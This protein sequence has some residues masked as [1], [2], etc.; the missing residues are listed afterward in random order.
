MD[1][2]GYVR[3]K[4]TPMV[5][6]IKTRKPLYDYYS[7]LN[8]DKPKVYNSD[9]REYDFYFIRDVHTA[10]K[11]YSETGR[12]FIW[13]RYNFGFKTHFYTHNAML[14]QMGKPEVKY[15]MLIESREI[16]PK[17]YRIFKKHPGLSKE[18]KRIFSFDDEIL[19]VL[20][21]ASFYPFSAAPWYGRYDPDAIKDDL[22]INKSKDVSFLASNKTMCEMHRIRL[23]AAR[24]CHRN[25]LA[26]VYGRC[27]SDRY[28]S[29][30]EPLKDYRYSFAIENDSTDYYFTEKITSCF[31][32]QTIP[33]Y[34]GAKKISEFFNPDG[35]I[36][37]TRDD[38]NNIE[39]VIKKCTKEEYERRLPAIIDNYN[40]VKS[41]YM[42]MQ[43]YLYEHYLKYD[44]LS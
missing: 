23:E 19:N 25:G 15:G 21:N 32:A 8:S 37:I 4:T 6:Y 3:A 27:V 1:I 39:R 24:Y 18:F 10:R 31:A 22:Y 9:G 7:Q 20:E 36:E 28:V 29:I 26:D 35:I 40:R 12:Y 43:D 2:K 42:N 33:I 38:L 14:Q 17:D 34:Y 13:D 41:D 16:V 30:E 44:D 5:G 11:P